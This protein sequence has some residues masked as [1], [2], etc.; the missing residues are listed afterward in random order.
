MM[1]LSTVEALASNRVPDLVLSYVF[2]RNAEKHLSWQDTQQTRA[3]AA[4]PREDDR[5][6]MDVPL[7][8]LRW[9][10]HSSPVLCSPC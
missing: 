5:N 7:V 9:S 6:G 4:P 1:L 3:I 10:C 8:L 2:M